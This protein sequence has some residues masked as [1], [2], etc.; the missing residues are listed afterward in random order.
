MLTKQ[1]L[2]QIKTIVRDEVVSESETTQRRLT[3]EIKL[4][5]MKIQEDLDSLKDR[6]KNLEIL[7]GK[8]DKK[9][10]EHFNFLDK[11]HLGLVKRVK[12]IETHFNIQPIADFS[13]LWYNPSIFENLIKAIKENFTLLITLRVIE[14]GAVPTKLGMGT[15]IIALACVGNGARQF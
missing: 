1:D 10:D 14:G 6:V 3:A 5:R 7:T 9:L 2:K 15:P 11:E 12:R 4:T 13:V 8:I